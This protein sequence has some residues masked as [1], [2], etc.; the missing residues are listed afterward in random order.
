MCRQ[1]SNLFCILNSMGNGA[2]GRQGVGLSAR[3]P[4]AR[5][6]GA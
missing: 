6:G 3:H 5:N 2:S 1:T 4:N